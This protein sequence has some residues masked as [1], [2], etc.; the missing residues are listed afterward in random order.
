MVHVENVSSSRS[1]SFVATLFALLN[2][3]SI[4]ASLLYTI[5]RWAKKLQEKAVRDAPSTIFLKRLR[6]MTSA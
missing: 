2:Q 3:L 1:W 5:W 4:D 6:G